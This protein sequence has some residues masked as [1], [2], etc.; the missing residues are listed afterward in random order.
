MPCPAG[1]QLAQGT[2]QGACCPT[3]Q[4]DNFGQHRQLA[5]TFRSEL[6]GMRAALAR[7]HP[8]PR[9]YSQQAWASES[10]A[11]RSA[12][13]IAAANTAE[14]RAQGAADRVGWLTGSEQ[15]AGAQKCRGHPPQWRRGG[16]RRVFCLLLCVAGAGGGNGSSSSAG[17]G[18]MWVMAPPARRHCRA[19]ELTPTRARPQPSSHGAAAMYCNLVPPRCSVHLPCGAAGVRRQ[20]PTAPAPCPTE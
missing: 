3:R 1:R 20:R 14:N 12:S 8:H 16:Y 5:A 2:V 7:P 4:A 10:V 19:S 11:V 17:P 6:F 13:S 18:A 9:R 15:A